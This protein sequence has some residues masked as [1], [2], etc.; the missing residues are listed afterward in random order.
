MF[1]AVPRPLSL[2]SE[3]HR[4][5]EVAMHSFAPFPVQSLSFG[6]QPPFNIPWKSKRTF[7][8]FSFMAERVLICKCAQLLFSL[9]IFQCFF[10][11]KGLGLGGEAMVTQFFWGAVSS[12]HILPPSH[13]VVLRTSLL[14]PQIPFFSGNRRFT[15]FL[16]VLNEHANCIS[17]ISVLPCF[18][19]HHF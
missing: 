18:P 11:G 3:K 19:L 5:R 16:I 15:R 14:S 10:L 13:M 1:E 4:Q 12:L 9:S 17:S 2:P 7:Q 8:C 6:P